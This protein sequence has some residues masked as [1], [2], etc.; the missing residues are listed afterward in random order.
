MH[1]W[2]SMPRTDRPKLL[3]NCHRNIIKI[4]LFRFRSAIIKDRV[5]DFK[6]GVCDYMMPVLTIIR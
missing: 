2:L 4:S 6:V 3:K 1:H 5:G